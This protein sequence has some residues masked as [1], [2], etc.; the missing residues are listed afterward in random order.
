MDHHFI[1]EL[2]R[3]Q[4]PM[5]TADLVKQGVEILQI[6]PRYSLED[7]FLSLTTPDKDV[8]HFAN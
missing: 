5:L 4:I 2:K 3:D 8:D 6:Q 7:F 1:F